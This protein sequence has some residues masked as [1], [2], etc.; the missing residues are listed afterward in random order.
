MIFEFE[1]KFEPGFDPQTVHSWVACHIEELSKS[2][3]VS[4]IAP[5]FMAELLAD[6]SAMVADEMERRA[7]SRAPHRAIPRGRPLPAGAL[8]GG[9]GRGARRQPGRRGPGPGAPRRSGPA[10]AAVARSLSA[11]FDRTPLDESSEASAS[12]A[13][14]PRVQREDRGDED[15]AGDGE[16]FGWASSDEEEEAAAGPPPLV[17]GGYSGESRSSSLAP[18]DGEEA[19]GAAS[20]PPLAALADRLTLS[21]RPAGAEAEAAASSSSSAAL[22]PLARLARARR[23]FKRTR[24]P[25]AGL[26]PAGSHPSTPSRA[27]ARPS[28]A[29]TP[30]APGR[31][32]PELVSILRTGSGVASAADV[33]EE[34]E[35]PGTP[36]KRKTPLSLPLRASRLTPF[37]VPPPAP[38]FLPL[39][40]SDSSEDGSGAPYPPAA[41]P[42]L[43][44]APPRRPSVV[45]IASGP[46]SRAVDI[47][48]PVARR[49]RP[50]LFVSSPRR[51]GPASP[52]PSG[53][54]SFAGLPSPSPF[55]SPLRPAP[56]A[57]SPARPTDPTLPLS[58]SL[59]SN[60]D[61]RDAAAAVL[62]PLRLHHLSALE[63]D[64]IERDGA[65]DRSRID[66][67]YRTLV[68]ARAGLTPLEGARFAFEVPG[69]AS[70]APSTPASGREFEYGGC[71][72]DVIVFRGPPASAG[73]AGP[74][75]GA[76]G[77]AGDPL[78][79]Y[80]RRKERPGDSG[81]PRLR[82]RFHVRS[83]RA[84]WSSRLL[85]GAFASRTICG[86]RCMAFSQ[87]AS[88]SLLTP[89]GSLRVALS[90]SDIGPARF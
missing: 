27:T 46:T 35:G 44:R 60:P 85:E 47:R 9:E 68:R 16:S 13:E 77:G 24:R 79:L 90:V 66:D 19:A 76:P 89:S 50:P 31:N 45:D 75:G 40:E 70:L 37:C 7:A 80:L 29:S 62:S 53:P 36:A 67:A 73:P 20:A 87:L 57:R 41:S 3:A 11:S 28:P 84:A 14:E 65:V 26:A 59:E 18:E 21:E 82:F 25:S 61:L 15:A 30:T 63:L 22:D 86:G 1:F 38:V 69:V 17:D 12:E 2:P 33:D 8:S 58:A 71:L 42:T 48:S 5:E 6:D 81:E 64:E 51:G 4:C 83:G 54:P 10:A 78:C 88:E 72:W 74:C 34:D 39:G 52:S 23:P 49:P 56:P 55:A 43:P 32:D